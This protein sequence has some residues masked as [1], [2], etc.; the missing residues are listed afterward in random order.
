MLANGIPVGHARHVICDRTMQIALGTTAM[1]IGQ[2]AR[3]GH[4]SLEQLGDDARGLVGHA[5]HLIVP[6]EI[7]EQKALEIT[8][9]LGHRVG[10]AHQR[11]AGPNRRATRGGAPSDAP[12]P[13][14][15]EVGPGVLFKY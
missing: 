5:N 11:H 4:E 1:I 6:I 13:V 9:P 7:F 15:G 3:I 8:G 2:Q 10:K 14:G 12:Y